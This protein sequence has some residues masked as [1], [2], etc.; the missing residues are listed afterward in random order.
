M[1]VK[2][3]IVTTS[4]T[5]FAAAVARNRGAASVA[6]TLTASASVFG[7]FELSQDMTTISTTLRSPKS[8]ETHDTCLIPASSSVSANL[9][10]ASDPICCNIPRVLSTSGH[11]LTATGTP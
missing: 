3:E 11:V 4:R 10:T 9:F 2:A 5:T 6:K 8:I 1:K 7:A